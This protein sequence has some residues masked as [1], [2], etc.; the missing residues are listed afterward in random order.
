M[1]LDKFKLTGKNA[2]VTGCS[3]GIGRA[4]AIGLA[5]AGADIIGVSRTLVQKESK[6]KQKIDLLN[7]KFTAYKADFSNRTE[8]Y[9]FI[10][11]LKKDELK[12]D[13]LIN[14]AGIV[15]RNYAIQY[16]DDDW[17]EVMEVNLNAQFILAREVGKQMLKRRNG[18]IIFISS[19]LSFQ[20]GIEVPAYSSS[21]GGI[22]QLTKALSNE[23]SGKGINVNSIAPGY[24]QTDLTR[25]LQTDKRRNKSIL[26]RIPAGRWGRPDDLVGA[27]VF[28]S[29]EASS[30]VSGE[31]ITIDGG[32]LGR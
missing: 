32:W 22:V 21:K 1:I 9:G 16:S 29:S 12:I 2:L 24:I 13:I 20:G 14:N 11:T 7:R 4:I 5:E 8:L 10:N 19:L 31:V 25:P 28:L 15:K 6:L 18:K 23:W 3:R 27:A 17:D 26:N 30:Y